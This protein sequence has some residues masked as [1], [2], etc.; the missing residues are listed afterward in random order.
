MS[1]ISLTNLLY[2]KDE[3]QIALLI[4][5]LNKNESA[6][7]WAY[8]LHYSGFNDELFN[9]IEKIYHYFFATLNPKF[10]NFLNRKM[11]EWRET[12][13]I[14]IINE[15]VSNLLI[16]QFNLDIFMLVQTC[17]SIKLPSSIDLSKWTKERKYAT[18]AKYILHSCTQTEFSEYAAQENGVKTRLELLVSIIQKCQGIKPG[19]NLYLH[20]EYIRPDIGDTPILYKVLENH[21]K[22]GVNESG[23]LGTFELSRPKEHKKLQEVWRINWLYY[24]CASPIWLSRVESYNGKLDHINK[25]IIFEDE[26]KE[27]DF[28]NN[29]DLEPDEQKIETQQKSI[30][31]IPVIS[32]EEFYKKFKNNGIYNVSEKTIKKIKKIKI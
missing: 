17:V 14:Q 30:P 7:F 31:E 22:Y 27:E 6:I 8:E 3:V 20:S 18:I 28:Y 1:S 4:S 23:L 11:N 16:R 15:I 21:C 29:F 2:L 24:A 12:E 13:D 10:K 32:F 26:E 25:K 5:L 19:H 9:L